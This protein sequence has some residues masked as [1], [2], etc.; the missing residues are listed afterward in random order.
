MAMAVAVGGFSP[1]EA[2]ELRRAMGAW[3][4]TGHLGEIGQRLVD[5]MVERG[6]SLAYAEQ[7]FSQIKGFGEYGFPESHSAS[8]ALLVYVSGWLKC[9]WPEAFAAALI[10]SQPMGFYAPR[11]LVADAQRHDVQVLPL[12]VQASEWDCSLERCDGERAALRLGLRLVRGLGEGH[13]MQ[14]LEARLRGPFRD[15][16]D[17]AVRSGLDQGALQALAEADACA[18]FGLNRQEVAWIFQGLW[19][20]APLF[21]GILPR[22]ESLQLPAPGEL[23][24]I[25]ADYRSVGLS[26]SRHPMDVFRSTLVC[27]GVRRCGDLARAAHGESTRVAGLVA[28]R[29][30]PGTANGVVFMTLEDET[31]MANLVVWP[32]VWERYR[33]I[34]RRSSMVGVSGTVQ[35]DG[36]AV[37]VLVSSF[38][39]LQSEPVVSARSRDFR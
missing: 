1:G 32:R 18:C 4:K 33:R 37:S 31:G 28:N 34:A 21:A 13:A 27:R 16:A 11:T 30:R 22:E 29:Q 7:V 20:D 5:R 38:W 9:H 24:E 15:P 39:L 26:V 23:D 12:C 17:L 14:L 19:I 6:M 36:E 2:D 25:R 35:R 8:F 3:R 10:N